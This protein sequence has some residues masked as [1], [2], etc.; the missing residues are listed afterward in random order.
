VT[1]VYIKGT[2]T[3]KFGELWD[4]SFRDLGVEA[5]VGAV[6]DAG[7]EFKDIDALYV[8]N[9]AAS[10][11]LGQDHL[12]A[13]FAT[14]LGIDCPAFHI[15][16]ACAS[17]SLAIRSAYLDILSGT[18]K[19]VL[20][21]GVEKMTDVSTSDATVGLAG[22]SD[23]EWEAFYGVTF[24]SL[25]AMIAREHMNRYA[26]TRKQLATIAVKNHYNGARNPDAQY[27]KEITIEEVLSSSIIA[28]PLSLFDCSP[29]SDGAA[30]IVLSS[31]NKSEVKIIASGHAQDSIALHDRKDITVIEAA[32]KAS[33]RAFKQAQ[34]QRSDIG[35]M[36][37]HDCFTIAEICA[38][39]DMGFVEKGKGGEF[40]E[41]GATALDGTLPTNTSGGLKAAGHPVGATG[42]KQACEITRQLSGKAGQ[43]QIK[44][45]LKYGLT[46][47]VGGSG[48]TCVINLF[49]KS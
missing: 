10:H 47:N 5:C 21:L 40:A 35:V 31:N 13:I 20:V 48:A 46:H 2:Y 45:D 49:K 33:Q 17:G 26:T 38:Y 34:I 14:E 42:V 11:Y 28:D 9:M 22:A 27:R 30:A 43:R 24:P 12:N 39:E 32:K 36:E 18:S 44:K 3:T 4:R 15:E 29:I 23:E 16:G 7:V 25:Y 41:S 8:A 6:K 1:N 19:N 37:V